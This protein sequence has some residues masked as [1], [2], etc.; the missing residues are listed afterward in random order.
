MAHLEFPPLFLLSTRLEHNRK[1]ELEKLVPSLTRDVRTAQIIVGN[2]SKQERAVYELRKNGIV[3]TER[4]A[5]N[6]V[7]GAT[8]PLR[9]ASAGCRRAV[10]IVRLD[11]IV[12]S[13]DAG[14]VLSI[15]NYL[16][17]QGY[18]E[19]SGPPS[20]AREAKTSDMLKRAHD[21]DDHREAGS[22][23]ANKHIRTSG[24]SKQPPLLAQTTS[25][26]TVGF[27]PIP[28]FLHTTYSCQRP[29]PLHPPNLDFINELKKIRTLRELEG[30]EVGV[31][32]YSTSIATLNAYPHVLSRAQGMSAAVPPT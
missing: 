18:A 22:R 1:A 7:G 19:P 11:W 30:N 12:D 23:S 28:S 15:D 17:Y 20:P 16:I 24:R 25:E 29:T 31:R 4:A 32:A 21:G 8:K 14:K 27:P 6:D 26:E 3:L 9:N 5:T 2:I 13:L 10:Q